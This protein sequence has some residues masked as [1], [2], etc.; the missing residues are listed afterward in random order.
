MELLAAMPVYRAYV[1]PGRAAARGPAKIV[2]TAGPPPPDRL[3]EP[4]RSRR[5]SSTVLYGPAEAVTRFQQ[6]CGPV[7]AK[8]V[9]DTALYRWFR[10]PA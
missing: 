6:T 2:E 5:S 4:L 8:G 1:V 3:P 7:M 10:W 9:E